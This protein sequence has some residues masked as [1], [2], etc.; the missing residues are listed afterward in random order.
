MRRL[1]LCTLR[2]LALPALLVAFL[3]AAQQCEAPGAEAASPLQSSQ[4]RTVDW[5][6]WLDTGYPQ[7][8]RPA[9]TAREWPR[10]W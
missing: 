1:P 7:I 8:Q 9:W 5:Y 4:T 2:A 3:V 6:Y 10:R